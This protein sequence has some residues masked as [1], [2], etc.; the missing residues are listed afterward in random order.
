M[1]TTTN[2]LGERIAVLETRFDTMEKDLGEIKTKLDSL[3]E[4]KTKGMGAVGLVGLIVSSG[5][6]GLIMMAVNFF[7]PGHL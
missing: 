1:E 7:K 4:L 6:I 2:K 5:V 3:L